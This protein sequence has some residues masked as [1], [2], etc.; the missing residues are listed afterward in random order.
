MDITKFFTKKNDNNFNKLENNKKKFVIMLGHIIN[1]G[2]IDLLEYSNLL[3]FNKSGGTLVQLK[4]FNNIIKKISN[5]EK[6]TNIFKEDF[7][8]LCNHI[9]KHFHELFDDNNN[10]DIENFKNKILEFNKNSIDFTNDQVNAI[11]NICSF[12]YDTNL[13]SYALYGYAGTGKTTIIIKLINF[14]LSKNYIKSVAFTAP[15]N[16][17]VN[18]MKS[19]FSIEMDILL[20]QA[21]NYSFNEGLDKLEKKGL[22]ISFLT[23]HKLLNYKNDF[24]IE[25]GRIFL[26][27]D[28]SSIS[29]YDLIL[30]DECSMIPFQII[31]HIFEEIRKTKIN[32]ESFK[33][34]PKILFVG[35]P[36]QLSPV[37]ESIS[38]IFGKKKEDFSYALFKKTLETDN[39]YFGINKDDNLIKKYEDFQNDILNLKNTLLQQVVRSNDTMVIGLCN[40]IR[41]WVIYGKIPTIYNFISEKV[42]VYK[43]NN[44]S[45]IKTEWFKKSLEYFKNGIDNNISN[46][47][48]TWTNRQSDEY[49]NNI[50]K[51]LFNKD[52]LNK[53]EIGD[54]L[55]LNDFYNVKEIETDD[56]QIESKKFYTSEQIKVVNVQAVQKSFCEFNENLIKHLSKLENFVSIE[57]KFKKTVR[58]INKNTI[59]KYD[60]W[61]LNVIKFGDSLN[62]QSEPYQMYSIKDE[63]KNI[64]EQDRTVSTEKI[65]QLRKTYRSLFKEN[66]DL[67]DREIIKPLWKE[68]SKKFWEPFANVN[69]FCS[70]SVHKSQSSTFFNVFVDTPDILLNQNS[71]EAKRL[72]YTAFTRVSNEL[73]ILI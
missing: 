43:Y 61:K 67:L 14:M 12:L 57:D 49:N 60:V 71:D 45:K 69:Y 17:A 1:T 38:I 35:D 65:R 46:I 51:M 73:H 18:I 40:N 19:K 4:N 29:N 44:I 24:D 48:L 52:K 5:D 16:Q 11:K 25:G 28:K 36:A 37:H 68:L 70:E 56:K 53:F 21:K 64:L 42:K 39:N 55:I 7:I 15:T 41:N 13:K 72:I 31:Y 47:I 10:I 30:I 20:N 9:Y 54:L 22:K 63:S 33:K 34:I 3:E 59:R 2:C 58:L 62:N 6:L 50:R 26:K 8:K 32:E 66:I 23:I 27:G